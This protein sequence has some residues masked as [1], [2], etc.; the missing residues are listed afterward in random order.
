MVTFGLVIFF[1]TSPALIKVFRHPPLCRHPQFHV[2]RR[3][4]RNLNLSTIGFL[5][6]LMPLGVLL[7]VPAD[8]LPKF[9]SWSKFRNL[10]Q[11]E[12]V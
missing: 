3:S 6:F 5:L 1:M 7:N 2:I 9:P 12:Q 11:M 10:I 8:G 4:R